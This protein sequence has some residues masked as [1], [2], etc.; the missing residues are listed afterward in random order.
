MRPF[1]LDRVVEEL[2]ACGLARPNGIRGCSEKELCD[3]EVQIGKKL[4]AAYREFLSLMGWYAGELFKGSD[5][6]Y[7]DIRSLQSSLPSDPDEF[8]RL[9]FRPPDDAIVIMSHQGYV[10]F[11][12]R[13]SEGDD[14]PVYRY[15]AGEPNAIQVNARFSE[16]LAESV[17]GARQLRDV[18]EAFR[19]QHGLQ[20]RRR[21]RRS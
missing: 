8:P 14:P 9:D 3:L 2:V 1:Y 11:Y 17:A 16:Y 15:M 19:R 20:R 5:A 4:P 7:G 10:Y 21:L 6:F 12:V 13:Q 18:S